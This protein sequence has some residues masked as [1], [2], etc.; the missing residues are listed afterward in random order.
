MRILKHLV[1]PDW[2]VMRAFPAAALREIELAIKGSE[3]RHDGELR[4]VVEAGLPFAFLRFPTRKRAEALFAELGVWDTAN[5]SGVLLYIELVDH[6]IEI[7]ADRGIAARVTQP[8]WDAICRR[9]QHAFAKKEFLAGSLEGI[10]SITALLE[11]HFPP[12]GRNPN[13]LPDKPV[14]L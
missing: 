4:F 3:R 7:V 5:N 12:R 11:Q 13:E 1:L 9:M 2:V 14:V 6:R 10:R 8:E